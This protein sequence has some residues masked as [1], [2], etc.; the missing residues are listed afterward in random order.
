MS[1]PKS[2]REEISAEGDMYIEEAR[3][4][5]TAKSCAFLGLFFNNS[6]EYLY[7]ISACFSGDNSAKED[8]S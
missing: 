7:T 5:S 6:L 3:K 1:E 2:S 4:K 8:N